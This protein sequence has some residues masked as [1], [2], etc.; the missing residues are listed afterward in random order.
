VLPQETHLMKHAF[1][2]L[3]L[4][5]VCHPSFASTF[6]V[7]PDGGTIAQCTGLTNAAYPGSGTAQ[8]CAWHHPFDALPPQGD[9]TNPAVKLHGG[10]TLLIGAGSYEMGLNAP[11]AKQAYRA[12]DQNW[13]WDCVMA[14]VPSGTS[15]QPTRILGVGWDNGCAAPPELWGSEHAAQVFNLSGSSNV[16]LGCLEITDH[17]SCIEWHLWSKSPDMCNRATPPFGAWADFGIR[18][19]DSANVTLQDLNIHGMANRG[20]IAGRLKD[21]TLRRVKL[22]ANPWAG[23]EGDLNEAAGSSDSGT[24]LFDTVEVGYNGCGETWPEKKVYGCWGELEGGYGDGL[25]APRTGGNWMFVNSYFHHNTQDGLDLLYA[26]PQATIS[27]LQTHAEGNAGN[28]IKLAGS[29]TVRNSVIVGNC[30][31]YYGVDYMSGNNSVGADSSGDICR[32]LGNSLVLS[33]QPGLH[34]DVQY[35]T[36]TG[37]GECLIIAINGDAT[38]SVSIENNA[39]IGKPAWVRANQNPKP[40]ACAFYWTD[41]PSTFPVRYA[42]DLLY[43]VKNNACPQGIGNQC[44][45]DPLIEDMSLG[46]FNATP[47]AGSPLIDK[48]WSGFTLPIDFLGN[49]RPQ[50]GGYDIG[51]IEYQSSGAAVHATS[52]ELFHNGFE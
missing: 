21:W 37:E 26:D 41:G 4:A 35:N 34:A 27:V 24:M 9:G 52:D 14:I 36:I 20:I 49:S 46:T 43:Q 23:W 15:T 17:S 40:N 10:D 3:F 31:Y 8:N 13:S 16:V 45:V 30:T 51:A 39:L 6:F 29:P 25:G 7:R 50:L 32:A 22:I 11:G 12:C 38:S 44:G 19:Q 47:L 48:A 2:A 1:L 18:A 42:G 28:Q 5:V 33:L